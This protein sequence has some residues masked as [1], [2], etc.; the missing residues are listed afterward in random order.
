[1]KKLRKLL[2]GIV[3]VAAGVLFALDALGILQFT[4]FFD[5]WWTL[6]IIVPCAVDLITEHNKT[7]SLI[8]IAIGVG[9][10]LWRQGIV[11]LDLLW[12]LLVPAVIILIGLKLIFGGLFGKKADR[13]FSEI[14]D[15]GNGV[16]TATAIFSGCDLKADGEVFEGAELNAVFGGVECDLRNAILEKDC[17]VKATAI[18]GGVSILVPKHV[19]VVVSS[20]DIFGGVSNDTATTGGTVTLYVNATAMFGGVDIE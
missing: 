2:W 12:K 15:S 16:K 20:T 9:L 11:E 14:K 5:G 8:G 3:L 6:F 7:G 1:M 4:L 13:R 10:L 19:N 17:T 18:F